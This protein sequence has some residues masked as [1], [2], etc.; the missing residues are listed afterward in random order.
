MNLLQ[1]N[2]KMITDHVMRS[3]SNSI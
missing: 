3:R 2:G 1:K